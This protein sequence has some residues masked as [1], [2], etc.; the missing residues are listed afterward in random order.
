MLVKIS[1]AA[2]LGI[3]AY[4]V[5]VE[6]DIS[7]GL[8]GF[9]T[10]GLP[11]AAVRESKERVRAAL[12]NC[13]YEMPARKLTVNLAPADRRKEG[14][15]FD[16]PI[17]LGLLAFLEVIPVER[18]EGCLFIGE[19]AMD[20]RLK[21]VRGI[22][23]AALLARREDYRAIVIPKENEK[24]AALV[25]GVAI[26]GLENLVQVVRWLNE[27]ESAAPCRYTLS[28]ILGPP[29]YDG[30][31]AEVKGQSQV[32][33]ALEVAAAGG[34]NILLI[35]PPGAGK[36]MLARRL[37]SILPPMAF[38]EIIEATEVWSAAG[39][40]KNKGAVCARPFRSPHHTVTDAGLIGGGNIPRPGE[41]SL[42][43]HGILFLDELP[44]FRRRVLEDLRQPLEDGRVTIA[45]AAI[46]ITYPASFMLVAAMN[47]CEDIFRGLAGRGD[48]CTDEQRQRYYAK[49]SGPL[50]DRIDIQVDV[51]EVKFKDIVSKAEGESSEKIRERVTRARERQLQRFQGLR[52][53][54]NAQMGTREI[55][56][57]CPVCADSQKL[58]E[59]AVTKLGFSARAYDRV[60][61]VARTIADLA[62][63]DDIRPAHVAEAIQYRMMDRFY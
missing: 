42:A 37:P 48:D 14:S 50:L 53:Y 33:R 34:H 12:K 59:T 57:F 19:L 63:E 4:I 5:D 27:P 18:L 26:F 51:P 46:S 58:L 20:G 24:E 62:A 22:L 9:V 11:D 2:L 21:P 29:S 23:P 47:P 49:I 10:V 17:S 32:K 54:A 8:P 13:G 39:L 35:G 30:D 45:R 60:L 56:K 38:D 61:K 16:L 55:K 43:H 52:I 1:S 44:E 6:V 28:E 41:V 25:D 31:F 40:L 3:D 15:A 36:T 7:P